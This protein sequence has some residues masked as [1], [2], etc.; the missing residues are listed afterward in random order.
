MVFVLA[1]CYNLFYEAEHQG[2]DSLPPK[3]YPGPYWTLH[4]D[5]P[6]TQ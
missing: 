5:V 1:N 6:T 3:V 4:R 2:P